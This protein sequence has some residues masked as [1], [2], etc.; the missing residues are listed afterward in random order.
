[1]ARR[2]SAVRDAVERG[3]NQTLSVLAEAHGFTDESHLNRRFHR[4]YGMTAG[5][6]RRAVVGAEPNEASTKSRRWRGW[7]VEMD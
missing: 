4:A 6:F 1:M 5:G 3:S 2:L 7:M